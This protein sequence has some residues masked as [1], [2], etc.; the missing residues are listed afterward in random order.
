M[1][2]NTLIS[3]PR[4]NA[5]Y[6]MWFHNSEN[7]LRGHN[8]FP[9]HRNLLIEKKS[10]A[11]YKDE[12]TPHQRLWHKKLNVKWLSF[13]QLWRRSSRGWIRSCCK[14]GERTSRESQQWTQSWYQG[15]VH[16]GLQSQKWSPAKSS[17]ATFQ[18]LQNK[19]CWCIWTECGNSPNTVESPK[20]MFTMA[21]SVS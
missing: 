1:G 12:Y 7:S 11:Q 3:Q 18:I 8:N 14:A 17:L 2:L 9:V 19:T 20:K 4:W 6:Q 5:V 13:E 16:R 15:K 10:A 21:M